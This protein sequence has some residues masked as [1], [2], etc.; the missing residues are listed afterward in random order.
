M[1]RALALLGFG[2]YACNQGL[3]STLIDVDL[4]TARPT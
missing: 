2:R 1:G 3:Y 4:C